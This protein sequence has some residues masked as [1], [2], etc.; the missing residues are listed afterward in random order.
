MFIFLLLSSSVI[1]IQPTMG[2]E[3]DI[4]DLN[5]KEI[6]SQQ[7]D[8]DILPKVDNSTDKVVKNGTLADRRYKNPY[9]I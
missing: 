5:I 1:I 3:K 8:K 7:I 6:E 2:I 9:N 4:I